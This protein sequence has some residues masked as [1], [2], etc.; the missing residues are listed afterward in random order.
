M[1][2]SKAHAHLQTMEK[3][4]AKFQN[5]WYKNGM[6]SCA[7]EVPTVYILRVKKESS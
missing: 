7:H 2:I 4:Y 1:I 6:R 3:I 5:D